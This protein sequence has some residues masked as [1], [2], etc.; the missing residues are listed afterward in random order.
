M[1]I[2]LI[3]LEKM[4]FDGKDVCFGAKK[5]EVTSTLGEPESKSENYDGKGYRCY[6]QEFACDFDE[7]DELEAIEFL[8]GHDG[9][10]KPIIYGVSAFDTG[11]KELFEI[12]KEHNN[13]KIDEEDE[14]SYGFIEISV[15]I[16]K[17]S[18]NEDNDFWSTIL[19][20]KKGYYL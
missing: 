1:Q 15:G 13:G 3:P 6:Y 5:E 9:N 14:D 8:H 7:N 4:I 17:D 18:A 10:L 12:L 19:I 16:W 11:R 2:E 20:G